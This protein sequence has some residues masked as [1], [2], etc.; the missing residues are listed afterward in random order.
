MERTD[1]L[2]WPSLLRPLHALALAA[3][4]AAAFA[5]GVSSRRTPE[6]LPVYATVP[7]FELTD[8]SGERLGSA[9]LSGRVWISDFIFT[10]CA[11]QCPTMTERLR[12]VAA[13]V[14]GAAIVSFSVDSEYDTPERLEAYA[15]RYGAPE[16]W[17]FLTG[18]GAQ[19]R[20]VA[21][22]IGLA[23][24]DDPM[25]HSQSFVLV[26]ARSR[27]RG[28]YDST[29]AAA[30]ERLVRDASRLASSGGS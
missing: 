19:V 27:V 8:R 23:A 26:D 25:L 16:R 20:R 22:G 9:D 17:F 1:A 29:D 21:E 30:V 10:R 4:V 5:W 18:D 2:S 28:F 13:R 12:T 7:A 11:G 15:R 24:P 6:E 14:N 3:A